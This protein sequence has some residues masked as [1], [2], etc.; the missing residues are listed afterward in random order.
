MPGTQ[1]PALQ[2]RVGSMSAAEGVRNAFVMRSLAT[3]LPEVAVEPMDVAGVPPD[4][5]E[6]MAFSLMGRNVL[7]GLPNQLPQCTGVQAARVLG[8]VHGTHF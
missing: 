5:A 4:A 7:L 6:A 2:G 8:V 1:W 3:A